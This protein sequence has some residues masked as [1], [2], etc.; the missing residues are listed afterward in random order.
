ML[1]HVGVVLGELGGLDLLAALETAAA[2]GLAF[3]AAE[4]LADVAV[5]AVDL[6]AHAV[7]VAAVAVVEIDAEEVELVA[8]LAAGPAAEAQGRERAGG[9]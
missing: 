6:A 2:A 1:L 4:E 9:R 8:G 7:D 3:G 5:G